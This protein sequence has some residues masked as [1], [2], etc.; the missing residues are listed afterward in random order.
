MGGL[1]SNTK[2][3]RLVWLPKRECSNNRGGTRGMLTTK[4]PNIRGDRT[5]FFR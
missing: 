2:F 5:R 3:A 1:A 4:F